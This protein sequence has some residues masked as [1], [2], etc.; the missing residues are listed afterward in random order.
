MLISSL[1]IS[2]SSSSALISHERVSLDEEFPIILLKEKWNKVLN[3]PAGPS[4]DLI[5][6]C[7][8]WFQKKNLHIFVFFFR[9]FS[10]RIIVLPMFLI[11]PPFNF[12]FVDILCSKRLLT[13]FS[14]GF[15]KYFFFI[16]P[17][18]SSAFFSDTPSDRTVLLDLR[19][20]RD[21][22]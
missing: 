16:P 5:V 19:N 13:N 8:P 22:F 14:F 2:L 18:S 1:E 6:F 7:P 12:F 21:D 10:W 15:Q 17:L 20:N 9:N 11:F 3:I 4:I